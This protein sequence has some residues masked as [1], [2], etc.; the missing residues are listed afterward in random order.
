MV[1]I[2]RAG[3]LEADESIA[4]NAQRLIDSVLIRHNDVLVWCDSAYTYT[5][6]NRVDAFG[7]VHVKQG[8]TLHLF[9]NKV[10]YDGDKSFARALNNVRLVNKSTTI[11]SDTLDYDLNLNIG[12]YEK[13][14]KIVDSTNTITSKIAKY[15][16]DEDLINFYTEVEGINK[17]FTLKSDTVVY[18]TETGRLTIEGPTTIRDSVNTIYAEDGWYESKTG[19]AELIKNPVVSNE[20][21]KIEAN[22]IKYNKE[23]RVGTALGS[24][25]IEDFENKTL[26]LGNVVHYND[27]LES[28]LVTD[29]A[30]YVAYTSSD[31]LFLH[32]DTL[33]TIPDTI[34]GEKIISAFYGVRFFREDLQGLCDSLVYFTKDSII[35]LYQNPVIWSEIHQ[36]SADLIQMQQ[37]ANAPDQL[38]LT[39]N[40]FIISEQDSGQFDQIKGKEMIAY[41]V[42]QELNTIDVNGNGQT[43]YYAR[44]EEEI[45]GLNRAESSKI[46][47]KFKDG[48]IF[49]ILFLKT[50]E[51]KLKPLI[52]LTKEEKQLAG[53]DW[54]IKQRPLSKHDIFKQKKEPIEM[55]KENSE[56]ETKKENLIK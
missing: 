30:V 44:E 32:A 3:S 34:E 48:K 21:Q 39:N 49:R 14:G 2:L 16:I 53:F 47:I 7:N 11:Y 51:G 46:S 45:I 9:A 18:N 38:Q 35:Q 17:D 27:T 4:S 43:L 42:D 12:Y 10:L 33:R 56:A 20:T 41:I 24:A 1:E 26:I 55:D 31:T 22:Y 36:L 13:Y 19:E 40:S 5:G 29:S 8:D 37:F 25:R 54:K 50:P 6:T 28:L 23:K 15:F 52:G